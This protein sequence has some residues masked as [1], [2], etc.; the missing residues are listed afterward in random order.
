MTSQSSVRIPGIAANASAATGNQASTGSM[1]RSPAWPAMTAAAMSAAATTSTALTPA[2]T[3]G[4]R[5]STSTP[6]ASAASTMRRAVEA[7][8]DVVGI[9]VSGGVFGQ[10]RAASGGTAGRRRAEPACVARHG[11]GRI[12]DDRPGGPLRPD[13]R[14]VRGVLVARAP[15]GHAGPAGRGRDRRRRGRPAA[16]RRRLRDRRDGGRRGSSLAGSVEIDGGR[17]VGGHARDR[18]ARGG[19]SSRPRTGAGSGIARRSPTTCPSTTAR[20]TSRSR[21]SC[22]S[23]CPSRYRALREMRRV[24]RPGARLA[25]RHVAPRRGAVPAGRRV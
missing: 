12:V 10:A 2:A 19:T 18:G 20:S 11:R 24:L 21:R 7:W 13:R 22:S 17:R 1:R 9:G 23:S 25:L 6:T 15:A 4:T 16:G 8:I 3:P 14:G 5:M